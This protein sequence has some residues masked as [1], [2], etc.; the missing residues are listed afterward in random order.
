MSSSR[1]KSSA[2]DDS[3][4]VA[5]NRSGLLL[6]PP[7]DLVV[8]LRE[9]GRY[10]EYTQGAFDP[11]VQALWTLYRGH[12]SSDGH[13]PTGP[14]ADELRKA[15]QKVG[16][17]QVAFDRDRVVLRRRDMALTLNGIAQ[18]YA[19]DRVVELLRSEGIE[20]CLVDMGETRAV[21]ERAE[22]EPWR[23]GITDPDA[24]DRIGE[25]LHLS[26]KAV[27]TSGSYGFRFDPAGRFN[28]L[29]DPRSG[30]CAE[31][32]RSVTAVL[33]T[34]TAADALSTA[35]SLMPTDAIRRALHVVGE[36]QVHLA[37]AAGERVLLEA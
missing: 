6:T 17:E 34:A 27:A 20:H 3:A 12:F 2:R 16:F 22:G 14:S 30:R 37:T 11:T 24:P 5:L 8:L 31:R 1:R 7:E 13:D 35:F 4:L 18:G 15:L 29:F 28:H 36:G 19:T 23:I 10:W 32:Y 21:G 26:D 25:T 33:S 9:C